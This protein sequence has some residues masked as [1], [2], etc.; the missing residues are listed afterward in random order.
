MIPN[1][2]AETSDKAS[3]VL[4]EHVKSCVCKPSYMYNELVQ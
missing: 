2:E 4:F 3:D 1:E